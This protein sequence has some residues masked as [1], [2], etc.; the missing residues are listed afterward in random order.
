MNQ[1]KEI[2]ADYTTADEEQRLSMFL[3]HR[4]L[5]QQ[6]TE[7]DMVD[8]QTRRAAVSRRSKG[9]GRDL[10]PY[11]VTRNCWGWLKHCWSAR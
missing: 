8:M 4:D 1:I 10:R 9:S 11:G 2:I 5:R 6:F 3:I 7:I